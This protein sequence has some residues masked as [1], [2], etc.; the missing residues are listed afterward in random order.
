MIS[1]EAGKNTVL[2]FSI[3]YHFK[4]GESGIFNSVVLFWNGKQYEAGCNYK[5][6]IEQQLLVI[7]K[8]VQYEVNLSIFNLS[9]KTYF[10]FPFKNKKNV[11]AS[12]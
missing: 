5:T 7:M 6:W 3:N 1:H 4:H 12:F 10:E 8:E 11:V 2:K 9:L